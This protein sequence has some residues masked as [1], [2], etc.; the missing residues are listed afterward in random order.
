MA[1]K[2]KGLGRTMTVFLYLLAVIAVIGTLIY[3]EQISILY[4]LTTLALVILLLVV[5]FSNLEA[6]SR[7]D[8]EVNSGM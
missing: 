4:V 7:G 6:V 5:G 2:K 3:L 1:N 8:E